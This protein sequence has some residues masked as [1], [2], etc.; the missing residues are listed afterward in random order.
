MKKQG[1]FA[2]DLNELM[3]LNLF[4]RLFSLWPVLCK[5]DHFVWSASKQKEFKFKAQ[6]HITHS[7]SFEDKFYFNLDFSAYFPDNSFDFPSKVSLDYAAFKTEYFLL[8]VSMLPGWFS[9][10]EL[11]ASLKIN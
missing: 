6:K 5:K 9:S 2:A 11:N 10:S 4:G 7:R 1:H 8:E 3:S